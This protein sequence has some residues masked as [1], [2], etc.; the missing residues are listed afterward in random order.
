MKKSFSLIIKQ[1]S[2][3]KEARAI[4]ELMM[5]IANKLDEAGGAMAVTGEVLEAQKRI[6]S[7][8]S[9]LQ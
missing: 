2:L 5:R 6:N 8:G 9:R 4:G 3:E 1:E 7:M